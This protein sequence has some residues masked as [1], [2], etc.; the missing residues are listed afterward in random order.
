M[1]GI[2]FTEFLDLVEARFSADMVD[3]IIDDSNVPSGGAYTAVAVYPHAEMVALV[4]SLSKLSGAPV[5][6]LL[7]LFGHHLFGRFVQLYPVFFEGVSDS[8]SFLS[9]VQ[10]VIHVEVKKLYP[11]AQLPEFR[12]LEHT[13]DKLVLQ[14]ISSRHLEEL[15]EGLIGGCIDHFGDLIRV[16]RSTQ[17]LE[18]EPSEVFSLVR[19]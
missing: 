10:N 1:K 17:T 6:D 11:D 18:G 4:S 5:G 9:M 16:E 14:Y 8:L 2:V 15:A 13:E 12:T 3:D 19:Y 7:R